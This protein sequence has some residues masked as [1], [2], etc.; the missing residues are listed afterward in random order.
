MKTVAIAEAAESRVAAAGGG[1]ALDMSVSRQPLASPDARVEVRQRDYADSA[2]R[3]IIVALFSFMAVR[4]GANFL[5]TGRLTGLLLLAS[6]AL[7]V[8]LTVFRRAPMVVDRSLRA[9]ML[10]T[11]AMMGPPLVAPAQVAPLVDDTVS[12]AICAAGLLVVIGGKLSLGRSFGLIPAN[13]GIVSTGLYRLVRHPI[14]LGYLITHVAFL[15]ANPTFWNTALLATADLAQLA[16]AVCEEHTLAKDEAYRD[17]Q[18]RVR[19]RIVPGI[20]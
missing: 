13:R 15:A 20:F 5:E 10:T 6:E 19:W 16:R 8:V 3:L 4:I 9:R 14:Y 17:Y 18:A 7:V 2:A 12:A 11:F 1:I